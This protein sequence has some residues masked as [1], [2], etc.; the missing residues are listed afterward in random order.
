MT[1]WVGVFCIV[2]AI[3]QDLLSATLLTVGCILIFHKKE[4]KKDG[5]E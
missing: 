1:K 3:S 4:D 5:V 2:L